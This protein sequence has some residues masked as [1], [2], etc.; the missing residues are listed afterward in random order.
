M[1]YIWSDLT[2]EEEVQECCACNPYGVE[3]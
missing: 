1:V 2:G 3:S